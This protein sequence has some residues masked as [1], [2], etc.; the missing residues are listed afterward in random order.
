MFGV[1]LRAIF[2]E[3]RKCHNCFTYLESAHHVNDFRFL[4][5]SNRMKI[6]KVNVWRH[7]WCHFPKI[8]EVPRTF[9]TYLKS[10]HHV[11]YFRF[12]NFSNRMKIKN[13]GVWRHFWCNF[14]RKPEVPRIFLLRYVTN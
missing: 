14:S 5:F 1:T 11:N 2:L 3:N 6:N 10:A 13:I 9:F 4:N 7:F 12:L 8:P